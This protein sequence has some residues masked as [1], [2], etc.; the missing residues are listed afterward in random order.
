MRLSA[1]SLIVAASILTACGGGGS[2]TVDKTPPE[3]L[4]S[5]ATDPAATDPAATDLAAEETS[6]RKAI[7]DALTA[8]SSAVAKVN[9]TAGNDVVT[10]A[11]TEIDKLRTAIKSAE[12]LSKDEIDSFRKRL[13]DLDS[14]LANL[15]S[16]RITAMGADEKNRQRDAISNAL[17]A[18]SSAVDEVN[19]TAGN[20]VVTKADNAI[21]KVDEEIK[22]AE[23]LS[24][25]E[26]ATFQKQLD[27]IKST[28]DTAKTNR[29]NARQAQIAANDAA[30][31]RS[32]AA[33][34]IAI[35]NAKKMF[36]A[37]RPYGDN[38]SSTTNIG[39]A[40]YNPN[41]NIDIDVVYRNATGNPTS[42]TLKE[43]K[44]VPKGKHPNDPKWKLKKYIEKDSDGNIIAEAK[45]YADVD[46]TPGKKFANLDTNPTDDTFKYKITMDNVLVTLQDGT[47]PA[48]LYPPTLVYINPSELSRTS[49]K[50]TIT[51]KTISPTQ[52]K[53]SFSYGGK[54]DGVEG[55]YTC[56]TTGGRSCTADARGQ[57][58]FDLDNNGGWTFKVKKGEENTE[59]IMPVDDDY[60]S[61]GW[62]IYKHPGQDW[63]ASAFDDYRGLT[64]PP[65]FTGSSVT[66]T[67]TYMGGATGWYALSSNTGGTNDS[68]NFTAKVNI[69][70]NFKSAADAATIDGTINTFK[71]ADGESRNWMVQLQEITNFNNDGSV[72][73]NTVWTIGGVEE[74]CNTS[75]EWGGN[76]YEL[77]TNDAP[78]IFT[79]H[80][81]T[82][83]GSAGKMVGSF[84]TKKQKQ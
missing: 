19:N 9:N 57:G 82:E 25:T 81:Y 6:Q 34:A 20:D 18:A 79:G 59:T 10:A 16:N 38:D 40:N 3:T 58:F 83:Y 61:Y 30:K 43:D 46:G 7:N 41:N 76:F 72:S 45:I 24:N 4:P 8:A 21:A 14:L 74:A 2:S 32:D 35:V 68:G 31:R 52:L 78:T 15:T 77:Q 73:S 75:C 13:G 49:G 23:N 48:D 53:T 67:A 33:A 1:L 26:K 29:D 37:I 62:W 71:G 63:T 47:I 17:T 44:T 11:N 65:S 42:V 5:I 55:T 54:Y 69:T 60:A 12:N 28:L 39:D 84:G 80:F 36:E 50:E 27:A 66:G 22:N 64:T 70:A 56:D 51:T